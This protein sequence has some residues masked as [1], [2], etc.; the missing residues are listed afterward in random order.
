[1]SH[2]LNSSV[3]FKLP[4][5]TAG[6]GQSLESPCN[7]AFFVPGLWPDAYWPSV[8]FK[9]FKKI[10]T[11]FSITYGKSPGQPHFRVLHYRQE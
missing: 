10:D 9:N 6:L 1:M 11:L 4:R 8:Q 2:I 5:D 3:I 7:W